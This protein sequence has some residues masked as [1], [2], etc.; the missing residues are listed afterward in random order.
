MHTADDTV[1]LLMLLLLLIVEVEAVTPVGQINND[2]SATARPAK[3]RAEN[4]C[5]EQNPR[6]LANMSAT[7]RSQTNYSRKRQ[8]VLQSRDSPPKLANMTLSPL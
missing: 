8:E 4:D 5:D 7:S 6:V 2:S 3:E 1:L